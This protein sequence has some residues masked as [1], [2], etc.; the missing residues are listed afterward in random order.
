M[1]VELPQHLEEQLRLF[2]AAHGRSVDSTVQEAV[3]RLLVQ[4]A[5]VTDVTSD[6]VAEAQLRALPDFDPVA[7]DQDI[8]KPHA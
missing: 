6:Q 7:W 1:T 3:Q 5:S 2:A 4:E 8:G